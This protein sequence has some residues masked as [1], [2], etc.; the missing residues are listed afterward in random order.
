MQVN[1]W[2]KAEQAVVNRWISNARSYT[3]KNNA[4]F[5]KLTTNYPNVRNMVKNA[6]KEMID[7]LYRNVHAKKTKGGKTRRNRR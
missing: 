5:A 6:G 1:V 4:K 7:S 3:R 2:N